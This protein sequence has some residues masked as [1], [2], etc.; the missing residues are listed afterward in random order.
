MT[1]GDSAKTLAVAGLS[2]VGRDHYGVFPLRGKCKNVRDASVAQLTSNQEFNDLKKILGLQQGKDYKDV[3]ELRYGRLMIMT[4]ADNDGSHIKGL[5]LNMIHYFWPS[6]LKLGFVVLTGDT[7]HQGFQGVQT[8]SFTQTLH[9]VLG[10]EMD[11]RGGVSSTTRVSV[12]QLLRKLENTSR[13]SRSD[14][15]V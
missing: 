14:C 6:L 5:I 13:N 4:D 2:V 9:S 10:M 3:S 7:N 11:N 1:E 12:P 15:Q 8:K